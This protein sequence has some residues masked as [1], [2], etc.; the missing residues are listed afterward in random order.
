MAD[1]AAAAAAG[2]EA[3]ADGAPTFV[4]GYGSVINDAS[5]AGTTGGGELAAAARVLPCFGARREW[6]FRSS[7]GFTALGLRRATPG[8]SVNGVVFQARTRA[9]A[10]RGSACV[11]ARTCVDEGC[12][13]TRC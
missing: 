9:R 13:L 12:A 2:G 5:R 10:K 6:N 4:F 3:A 7:T 1:A 11:Y 8:D